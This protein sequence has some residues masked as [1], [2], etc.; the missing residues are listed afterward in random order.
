MW[1]E[2]GMDETCKYLQVHQDATLNE[3]LGPSSGRPRI[4]ERLGSDDD[5]VRLS[6]ILAAFALERADNVN[7]MLGSLRQGQ[8]PEGGGA[9]IVQQTERF[10]RRMAAFRLLHAAQAQSDRPFEV[11]LGEPE[12][13]GRHAAGGGVTLAHLHYPLVLLASPFATGIVGERVVKDA[14]EAYLLVLTFGDDQGFLMRDADVLWGDLLRHM[15]DV[16]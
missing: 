16:A 4:A 3:D 1:E 9:W 2:H 15:G 6:G 12:P 13:I 5:R 11:R 10:Q 8:G 14:G 7:A